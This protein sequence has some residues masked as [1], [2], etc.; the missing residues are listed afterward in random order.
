MCYKKNIYK[1]SI[2]EQEVCMLNG[3]KCKD[4]TIEI[5]F[6]QCWLHNFLLSIHLR[7]PCA[8]ANV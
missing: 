3:A 8:T 7:V 1:T 2:G 4:S 6:F 5:S